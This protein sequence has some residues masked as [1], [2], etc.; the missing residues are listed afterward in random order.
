MNFVSNGQEYLFNER[1]FDALN[2]RRPLAD[3]SNL[4][5]YEG[6]ALTQHA[7]KC[8]DISFMQYLGK[9][10]EAN[11]VLDTLRSA[12]KLRPFE[13]ALDIGSGPALQLR[14]M[15]MAGH[16]KHAD[17]IDLYDGVSRCPDS[18]FISYGLMQLALNSGYRIQ[19]LIP[20][21][22]ESVSPRLK[23]L[24]Q[25]Y[26]IGVDEFS[27]RTDENFLT[28]YPR[29][30]KTIDKFFV[31]DIYDLNGQYDLITSYMAL[32]YFDF[33]EMAKKV[34]TILTSGGIFAFIV[35]YWWYPINNTLLYGHFPYL[36]QQL[37]PREVLRYYREI[38]PN[39]NL[40]NIEHR[41]GY[42][43]QKRLTISDYQNIAFEHNLMP[44]TSVRLRPVADDNDRAI[45]G[46]VNINNNY[47]LSLTQVLNNV[48]GWKSGLSVLDLMTSHVL[49]VFERQ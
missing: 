39:L 42:S 22:L 49:L 40:A 5:L 10:Y 30:R 36:L 27:V 1:Y 45:I 37:E 33:N 15:K 41:L 46:P 38:H 11:L 31:G 25:K 48:S 9:T 19:G 20:C 24:R 23:K 34:A 28:F 12:G 17:A 2:S 13:R 14:Y 3:V 8:R 29:I 43:D 26:P 18:T 16:I 47:G 7:T 6:H 4:P 44:L 32:D 35:S 21:G